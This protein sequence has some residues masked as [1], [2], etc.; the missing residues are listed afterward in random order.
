MST[1][2]VASETVVDDVRSERDER[3]ELVLYRIGN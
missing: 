1:K 2:R 3:R